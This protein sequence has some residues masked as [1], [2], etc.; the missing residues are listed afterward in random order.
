MIFF[1]LFKDTYI[2]NKRNMESFKSQEVVQKCRDMI[3][4]QLE[5]AIYEEGPIWYNEYGGI[6]RDDELSKQLVRFTE[7]D[8]FRIVTMIN[9]DS[10]ALFF[11]ILPVKMTSRMVPFSG[12]RNWDGFFIDSETVKNPDWIQALNQ[13]CRG[14]TTVLVNGWGM[15]EDENRVWLAPRLEM[16][17]S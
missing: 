11:K 4:S 5:D 6:D 14:K 17:L 15:D 9:E 16:Y 8:D 3:T 7:T 1:H 2:R 12:K 10:S 13:L